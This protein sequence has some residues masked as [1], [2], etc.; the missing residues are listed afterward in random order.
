LWKANILEV[1][2]QGDRDVWLDC[3]RCRQQ[4]MQDHAGLVAFQLYLPVVM[5]NSKVFLQGTYLLIQQMAT[6]NAAYPE[7]PT[8]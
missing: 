8:H 6:S 5:V 3:G 1:I 2:L 7:F 4:C